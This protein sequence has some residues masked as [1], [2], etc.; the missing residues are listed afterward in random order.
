MSQPSRYGLATTYVHCDAGDIS[1]VDSE[2]T[3]LVALAEGGTAFKL[4]NLGSGG[5]GGGAAGGGKHDGTHGGG[6]GAKGGE[7]TCDD[8]RRCAVPGQTL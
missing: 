3:A 1:D 6:G 8:K 5:G 4:V 2:A 7:G